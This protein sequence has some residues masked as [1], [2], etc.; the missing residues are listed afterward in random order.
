MNVLTTNVQ[1]KME[2]SR[3]FSVSL[4]LAMPSEDKIEH[5]DGNCFGVRRQECFG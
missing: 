2:F 5:C 4:T 1:Q 3:V